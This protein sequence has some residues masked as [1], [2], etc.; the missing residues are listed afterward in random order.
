MRLGGLW[1]NPDFLK[2]WAGQSVSLF[3]SQV[4]TLA[5]PLAAA[6]TLRATPLQVAVLNAAVWAPY[7]VVGLFAGLWVDRRRRRPILVGANLGRALLFGSVPLAYGLGVLRMELLYVVAFLT[8]ALTVLFNLAYGSYLPTLVRREQLVEGNGKMQASASVAEIGGPGLGGVLVQLFTAPLAIL[9]DACSYLVSAISLSLIRAPEPLPPTS[10]RR[11]GVWREI[12]SGLRMTYRNSYLRALVGTA[13][14]Y[15]LFEQVI[16]AL[17]VVYA[18]RELGMGAGLL[19]VVLGLGS[20]GALL[21][22]LVSGVLARRL[23]FGPAIIGAVAVECAALLLVPLAA[24]PEVVVAA[25]LA[26]GFFF[27]GVGLATS[28]VYVASLKQA[29][30]P[31]ELLGRVNASYSVFTL[32]AI[33]LGALLGGALQEFIGLRPTLAFGALGTLLAVPWVLSPSMRKLRRL[34]ETAEIR[35]PPTT[36]E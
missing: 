34:P 29:I 13:A 12:G 14:T 1:H 7:L 6:L 35:E 9:V 16:L 5:L 18:T 21:G 26:L 28:N 10:E 19:G 8:G 36:V 27:N 30:T 3:G 25:I 4:T 22:S 31:G 11:A 15:N 17:L 23:G 20:C 33:P 32:G 2:L 24:G